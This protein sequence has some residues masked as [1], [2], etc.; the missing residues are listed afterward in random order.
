MPGARGGD[1]DVV[2]ETASVDRPEVRALERT[3]IEEMARR[4]GGKGPAALEAMEFEPPHGCFVL[5]LVDGEAVA[6]GGFRRL[7]ETAAEVKRMWVTPE[8]RRYGLG[9][10]ILAFIHGQAWTFGYREMWLETGTEQPEAIAMYLEA[11][12]GPIEPYGEF[13][14][15]PRSRCYRMSMSP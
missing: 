2:L 14:D 1:L 6:C 8:Y 12:Y 5:A 9:R 7:A 10:R 4:Y 13:K 11:G 15:D 3:F